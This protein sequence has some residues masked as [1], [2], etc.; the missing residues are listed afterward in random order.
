MTDF[1]GGENTDE[2]SG[3]R[4]QLCQVM[5]EAKATKL[6]LERVI[7][8]T[9][10]TQCKAEEEIASLCKQLEDTELHAEAVEQLPV[11]HWEA[12]KREQAQVDSERERGQ[13]QSKLLK[14]AFAME[15]A[16]LQE[17]LEKLQV[18]IEEAN[19]PSVPTEHVTGL[20]VTLGTESRVCCRHCDG[21]HSF[22]RNY[23]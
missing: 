15:K 21:T 17:E 4:E 2:V 9:T 10:D 1:E 22:D 6:E 7:K 12:I 3:L 23:T 19:V 14:D 11:E 16:A 8:V 5:A 13:E 18:V 20:D